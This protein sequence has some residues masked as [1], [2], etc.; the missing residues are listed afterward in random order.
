M[1][2]NREFSDQTARM[3]MLTWTYVVRKLYKGLFRALRI[4]CFYADSQGLE[5][6]AHVSH[7]LE[8]S[9]SGLASCTE[10]QWNAA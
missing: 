5:H 3:R 7:M 2:T 10:N 8:D 9:Y 6:S 4:I 1:S